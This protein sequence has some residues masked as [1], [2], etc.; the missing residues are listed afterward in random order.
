MEVRYTIPTDGPLHGKVTLVWVLLYPTRVGA[1][2][3]C[4]WFVT[5]RL[6]SLGQMVFRF[7][8]RS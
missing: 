7:V 4:A 3:V 6:W 8:V 5:T 1:A 2:M